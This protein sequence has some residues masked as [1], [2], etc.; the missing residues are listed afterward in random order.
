MLNDLSYTNRYLLVVKK[1]NALG[2]VQEELE[3]LDK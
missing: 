1:Q 3:R 2:F